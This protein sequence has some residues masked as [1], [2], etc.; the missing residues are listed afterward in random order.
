LGKALAAV[1]ADVVHPDHPRCGVKK[2]DLDTTWLPA[3]GD[4][5]LILITRDKRIRYRPAEK[6]LMLAYG[7]R[8]VFLTGAGNTTS[9]DQLRL[10]VRHWEAIEALVQAPGPWAQ[11][12]TVRGLRPL[13]L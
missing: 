3:I 5:G 7:V 12:L 10:I 6:R 11:S 2:G 8:G 13:Q 4:A 9:W 1:R